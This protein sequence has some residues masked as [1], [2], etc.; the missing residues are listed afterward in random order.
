[1][2]KGLSR[3]LSDRKVS[4][5]YL[6]S[7]KMPYILPE[8]QESVNRAIYEVENETGTQIIVNALTRTIWYYIRLLK[9][10]ATILPAYEKLLEADPDIRPELKTAW[11][12]IVSEEYS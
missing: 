6:L 4:R 9:D 2:V 10:P 1:M 5:Y 3:K 12:R 7:T 11:N 8:D